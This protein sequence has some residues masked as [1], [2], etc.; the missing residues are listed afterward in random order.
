VTVDEMASVPPLTPAQQEWVVKA[1]PSVKLL[2]GRL[3]KK[4][5]RASLDDIAQTLRT[6]YAEVAPKYNPAE[7][8][9]E[10]FGYWPAWGK[11]HDELTR[12]ARQSPRH[13]A[14][15][16]F[17][18]AAEP[19]KVPTGAYMED[20]EILAPI[21]AAC[22]DGTFR[23]FFGAT[24]DTWRAQGEQGMVDHLTR[25]KAFRALQSAFATLTPDEWKLLELYY[26]ECMTWD[27][28]G[29]ALDVSGRQARRR[30]EQIRE[31][32]KLELIALGVERAPPEAA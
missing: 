29:A 19:L 13:M 6:G 1:E 2:A 22:H 7:G 5:P 32:L 24:F 27:E 4:F 10:A 12:E 16:A 17:G 28:V 30:D 23:M 8:T 25:L 21:K 20:D 14:S 26:I 11:A 9:F 18:E 15:K 31:K 3:H